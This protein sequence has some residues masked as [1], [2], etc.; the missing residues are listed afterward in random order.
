M[1]PRIN[2]FI[3]VA[4]EEKL[5]SEEMQ[6]K[7]RDAFRNPDYTVADLET[8]LLENEILSKDKIDAIKL[9]I[10][11]K[12]MNSKKNEVM[13]LSKNKIREVSQYKKCPFCAEEV[14]FE[15]RKCKHCGEIVDIVLRKS[16]ESNKSA[17]ITITNSYDRGNRDERREQ[18]RRTKLQQQSTSTSETPLIVIAYITILLSLILLPPILGL[19][20]FILAIINLTRGH[21]GHGILQIIL[22]IS[23]SITGMYLGSIIWSHL[24]N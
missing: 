17:N 15:A 2:D 19:I 23:F 22:S 13:V 14:L 4:Y 12:L 20:G 3:D 24:G 10:I 11:S 21:I 1:N 8:C 5:L 18:D 7:L 6:E 9:K 16:N